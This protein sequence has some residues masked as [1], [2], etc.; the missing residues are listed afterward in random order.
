MP[1]QTS[2]H[3]KPE[4][5]LDSL[6]LPFI[7]VVLTERF[8]LPP[9]LLKRAGEETPETLGD[10]ERLTGMPFV[11]VLAVLNEC[12]Q[13]SQDLW[14][15]VDNLDQAANEE[16]TIILDM[17]PDVSFE[18]EPL[19]PSAR[20]FHMHNPSALLPHLRSCAKVLVLSHSESHAW[21]A[22]MSLRKMSISAFLPRK[23]NPS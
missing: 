7:D 19:H 14:L 20:I 9:T 16:G 2:K 13:I 6:G 8:L 22:A 23:T 17:R 12:I 11:E 21:S 10:V 5:R 1:S 15:A 18:T 4:T 3:W